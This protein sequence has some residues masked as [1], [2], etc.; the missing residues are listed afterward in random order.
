MDLTI[1]A[2]Q[3]STALGEP[4]QSDLLLTR[5]TQ[6]MS[7]IFHIPLVCFGIAFPAMVV[8]AEGL[9]L[10]TGD[11][12]YK[13]LAKRWSKVMLVLFAVG[14]VT[15]TILSFEL[16]LLWPN[17]MATFG[18]VF[19]L[20]F[21]LE[22]F[23]FF[24]EAIFIAIYVYGWDRI[25]PPRPLPR[26]G[27]GRDHRHHRLDAGDRGER[28][29]EQP[30]RASRSSTARSPT[31]RRGRRC[32]TTSS[33]FEV[34]HMYLAGYLVVGLHRRR[35]LRARLAARRARPLRARRAR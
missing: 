1:A 25:S 27:R 19:G 18:D 26:R 9:W 7:F 31:S 3:L 28:L 13:A 15:G 32:S 35:R 23:S 6:A 16:G 20:G 34:T 14:V 8:F 21:A 30:D 17:F 5:Q 24:L 22:G 11:P 33:A 12:V 4:S 2:Q 10:R 29:D